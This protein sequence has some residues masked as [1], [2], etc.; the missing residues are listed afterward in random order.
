MISRLV[1]LKKNKW[2]LYP[3]AYGMQMPF[4][5]LHY[6]NSPAAVP[7]AASMQAQSCTG[8]LL[9]AAILWP[10]RLQE[11]CY[12]TKGGFQVWKIWGLFPKRHHSMLTVDKNNSYNLIFVIP[13]DLLDN[14]VSF[15][16]QTN[17]KISWQFGDLLLAQHSVKCLTLPRYFA[18][19]CCKT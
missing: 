15:Q 8:Y 2:G 7:T 17:I 3:I 13:L 19:I 12:V 1:K 4:I 9:V 18:N 11:D 14:L 16:R 6:E 10:K 5:G